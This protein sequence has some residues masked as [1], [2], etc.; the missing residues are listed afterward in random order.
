[1]Q[2]QYVSLWIYSRGEAARDLPWQ[3]WRMVED[4]GDWERILW[5]DMSEPSRVPR[6]GDLTHWVAYM[7]GPEDQ[8]AFL[9]IADNETGDLAG[10]I[11]FNRMIQQTAWGS[12]WV[13]PKYRGKPHAREAGKLALQWAHGDMGWHTVFTLTPWPEV[14]NFDKRLGFK[15]VTFIPK[16]FG[17]D[18]W[19]MEHT[20]G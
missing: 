16:I 8:K 7:H 12:I 5:T 6:W 18:V 2:G 14:R 17:P 3:L 9:L 20:N 1:M 10:F 11:W 4:A 19:L 15:D 13:H